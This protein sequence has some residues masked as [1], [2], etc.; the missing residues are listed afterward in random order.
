MKKK[1]FR[2]HSPS[3][4][5]SIISDSDVTMLCLD[6]LF[7]AVLSFDIIGI[8]CYRYHRVVTASFKKID[9]DLM[10]RMVVGEEN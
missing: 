3:G 1:I 4:W 10:L 6:R 8:N 5:I 9:Y 7:Y 2:K